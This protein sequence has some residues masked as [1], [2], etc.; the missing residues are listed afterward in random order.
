MKAVPVK[1]VKKAFDLLD[2]LGFE[3]AESGEALTNLAKRMGMPANS[4]HNLLKTMSA[5]GYVAQTE[6]SRYVVG[7]RYEQIGIRNLIAHD[8]VKNRAILPHLR[9]AGA[10]LSET[11][12][13]AVLVNGDRITAAQVRDENAVT[14]NPARL[15]EY[16]VYNTPTGRV[17]LA[18]CDEGAYAQVVAKW[19]MPHGEWDD[20]ADERQ[21]RA[22]LEKIR[23]RR[24]AMK[25]SAERGTASIAV[26]VL[27]AGGALLG[28]L[29]CPS[30]LF[31]FSAQKRRIILQVLTDASTGI[32]DSIAAVS[33]SR[34]GGKN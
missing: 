9:R 20:I 34:L 6:Q 26:P 12:L 13:L 22:N 31:R 28:A 19:G 7:A 4:V 1:A 24:H 21:L 15:S 8:E 30:P 17:L 32:S 23:R 11:V 18:F 16:T 27:R 5:C 33:E 10:K 29:G 2:I 3:C 25:K 14:V